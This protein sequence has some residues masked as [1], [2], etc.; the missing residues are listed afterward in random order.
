MK[1]LDK[2]RQKKK[3]EKNEVESTTKSF[4]VN[5]I[6]YITLYYYNS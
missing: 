6:D 3:E 2:E 5:T 4:L 1:I